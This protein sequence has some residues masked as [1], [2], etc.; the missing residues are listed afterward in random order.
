MLQQLTFSNIYYFFNNYIIYLIF[1]K[2]RQAVEQEQIEK[3]TRNS[4]EAST[5]LS[6]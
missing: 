1:K 3:Y 2:L 5:F 4:K 6:Y